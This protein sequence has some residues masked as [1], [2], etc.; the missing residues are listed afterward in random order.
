MKNDSSVDK[1]TKSWN[2]KALRDI[3][4]SLSLRQSHKDF[5]NKTP[6]T[7]VTGNNVLNASIP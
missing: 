4:Q 7:T 1:K 2:E 5:V 3:M 6:N